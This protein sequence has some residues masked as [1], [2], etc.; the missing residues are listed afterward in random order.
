M[1][2]G[3][4]VVYNEDGVNHEG[5]I[6]EFLYDWLALTMKLDDGS[7]FTCGT[8]WVKKSGQHFLTQKHCNNSKGGMKD[9]K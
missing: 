6:I 2:V 7:H 5:E 9:G 4:R 1:V 3:D 8:R